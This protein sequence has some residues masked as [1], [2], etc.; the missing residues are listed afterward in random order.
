MYYCIIVLYVE[1]RKTIGT[2]TIRKTICGT[3][4]NILWYLIICSDFESHFNCDA[5]GK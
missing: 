1:I 2:E 3:E 4:W 5:D